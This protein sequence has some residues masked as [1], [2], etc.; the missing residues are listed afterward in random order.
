MTNGICQLPREL[1]TDGNAVI[2]TLQ[3]LAGAVGTS[4]V[5]TMVAAAQASTPNDLAT[6]TMLGSQNAFI[7]LAV[8]AVVILCCS[9]TVFR[10]TR[11]S[12]RRQL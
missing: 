9:C 6:A 8:L 12:G 7:L 10:L 11:K 4:V 2:N 1:S 3:Q 5:A